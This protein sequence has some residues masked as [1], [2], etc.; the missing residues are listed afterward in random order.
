MRRRLAVKRSCQEPLSCF[1]LCGWLAAGVATPLAHHDHVDVLELRDIHGFLRFLNNGSATLE[2]DF[3]LDTLKI[4]FFL[5]KENE[6]RTECRK[7]QFR[8]FL[9]EVLLPEVDIFFVGMKTSRITP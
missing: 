5:S 6:L 4:C 7:V 2:T 1:V 8:N 9:I 3:N